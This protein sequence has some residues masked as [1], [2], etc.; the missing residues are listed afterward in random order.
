MRFFFPGQYKSRRGMDQ[1]AVL[2]LGATRALPPTR[3]LDPALFTMRPA[4]LPREL[5]LPARKSAP[6]V[7]RRPTNPAYDHRARPTTIRL[8]L[9]RNTTL[10]WIGAAPVC[11]KFRPD[12][13]VEHGTRGRLL[14]SA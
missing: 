4:C 5:T 8:G 7:E 10:P 1:P 6:A 14:I 9:I 3:S 11:W 13:A 12:H 2:D